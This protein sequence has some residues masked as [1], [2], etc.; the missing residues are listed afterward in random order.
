MLPEYSHTKS[1]SLSQSNPYYHG[2]NTAF[3]CKELLFIGAPCIGLRISQVIIY[4]SHFISNGLLCQNHTFWQMD[5]YGS[6]TQPST[7]EG[8]IQF[9]FS[10][11]SAMAGLRDVLVSI[12]KNL[13]SMND[14][15]IHPRFSQLLLLNGRMWTIVSTSLSRTVFKTLPLLKW[16]WLPVTLRTLSFFTNTIQYNTIFVY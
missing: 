3:F 13:Q 2:W 7:D 5:F 4:M 14:R 15:D 6:C 8:Q 16:T 11:S 9:F 10:T 12:E 1:E